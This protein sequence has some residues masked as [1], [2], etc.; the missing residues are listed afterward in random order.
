MQA[1]IVSYPMCFVNR[2]GIFIHPRVNKSDIPVRG[3]GSE[4]RV[5]RFRI[6]TGMTSCTRA[7]DDFVSMPHKR[8]RLRILARASPGSGGGVGFYDAFEVAIGREDLGDRK[9]GGVW[10]AF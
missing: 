8:V 9:P 2:L 6:R 5:G 4:R 3:C 10:V 1:E 7:I